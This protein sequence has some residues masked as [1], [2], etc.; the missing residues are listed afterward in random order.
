[1]IVRQN[2]SSQLPAS[3]QHSSLI[4]VKCALL[5]NIFKNNFYKFMKSYSNGK[6]NIILLLLLCP[7]SIKGLQPDVPCGHITTRVP[8]LLERNQP[9]SNHVWWGACV[10]C[11]CTCAQH[12]RACYLSS[13]GM[14]DKI[15]VSFVPSDRGGVVIFIY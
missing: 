11:V 8:P 1:M 3:Q 13:L 12:V 2:K 6:T 14:P 4:S 7:L 9:S 5:W 15:I 10:L